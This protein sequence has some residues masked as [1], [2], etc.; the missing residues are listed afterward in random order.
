MDIRKKFIQQTNF[1]RV[2]LVNKD[3]QLNVRRNYYNYL[4]S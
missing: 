3:L 4:S 1:E 2:Q